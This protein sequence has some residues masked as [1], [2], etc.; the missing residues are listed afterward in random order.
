MQALVSIGPELQLCPPEVLPTAIEFLGPMVLGKQTKER[1]REMS[2]MQA[3][4]RI[5]RFAKFSA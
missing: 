2:V 3:Q 4:S 5:V 1:E